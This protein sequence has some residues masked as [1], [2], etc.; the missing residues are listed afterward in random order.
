METDVACRVET[1]ALP[2]AANIHDA[3]ERSITNDAEQ[4]GEMML[5]NS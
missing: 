1:W 4:E 5:C 3:R 2:A